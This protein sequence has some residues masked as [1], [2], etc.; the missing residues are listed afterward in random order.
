VVNNRVEIRPLQI[1]QSLF[2]ALMGTD[3]VRFDPADLNVP[4]IEAALSGLGIES[5]VVI[6]PYTTRVHTEYGAV[7]SD[8][9]MGKFY[10]R[11]NVSYEGADAQKVSETLW[12]ELGHVQD[13]ENDMR[14]R[15]VDLETI[16][17]EDRPAYEAAVNYEEYRRHPREVYADRVAAE[18]KGQLLAA[19]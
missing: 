18:N 10:I 3:P 7:S 4:A 13:L 19:A 5:R 15:G 17:K 1:G 6:Q 16:W 2:D 11:L 14:Q 9:R 12:H 8:S